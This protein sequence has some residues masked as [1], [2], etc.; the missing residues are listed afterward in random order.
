[1][2][3]VKFPPEKAVSIDLLRHFEF[4]EGAMYEALANEVSNFSEAV[5]LVER[6][7]LTDQ[8]KAYVDKKAGDYKQWIRKSEGHGR[9]EAGAA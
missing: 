2:R 9:C 6:T 4:S 5:D 7:K 3:P 1:M 8:S